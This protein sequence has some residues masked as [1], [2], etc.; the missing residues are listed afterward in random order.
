MRLGDRI[1]RLG[2]RRRAILMVS[3]LNREEERRAA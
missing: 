1:D 2:M 3:L